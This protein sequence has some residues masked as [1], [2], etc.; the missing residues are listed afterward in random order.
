MD[1]A[2]DPPSKLTARTS[3]VEHEGGK[4]SHEL[5]LK[6]NDDFII[7][8]VFKV[9][10]NLL[11]SF[12]ISV[13]LAPWSTSRCDCLIGHF[14]PDWIEGKW[15]RMLRSHLTCFWWSFSSRWK[16]NLVQCFLHLFFTCFGEILKSTGKMENMLYL[17]LFSA[18]FG[19]VL[20]SMV[21]CQVN[22]SNESSTYHF[23]L[24]L[25]FSL[26]R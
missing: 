25:T 14:P 26:P 15:K 9:K 6:I 11:H 23:M 19:G 5:W 21:T 16:G 20:L 17:N 8:L 22:S 18:V 7:F 2:N 24:N 10:N 3:A 1:Y 4:K 12:C 13:F